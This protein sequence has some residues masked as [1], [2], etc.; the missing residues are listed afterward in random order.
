MS[1]PIIRTSA[2]NGYVG[3]DVTTIASATGEFL[4]IIVIFKLTRF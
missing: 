4:A 2:I 3:K 1:G